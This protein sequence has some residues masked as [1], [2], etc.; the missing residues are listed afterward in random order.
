[1]EKQII[2][3]INTAFKTANLALEIN[4]N[5]FFDTLDANVKTSENTLPAIEK[6]LSSNGLTPNDLTHLAVVIGTG[7]FTGIRVGVALAKGFAVANKNLKL[8]PINS[9]HLMA[10]QFVRDFKPECEFYTIQN[11][12][13]GRFFISKYSRD[14]K[15]LSQPEMVSELPEN[16]LFVGLEEE[17]LEFCD[18]FLNLNS[19]SL[20]DYAK[21]LMVEEN[22]VKV[23]GLTPVYLRLSQAEENLLKSEE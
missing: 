3:A 8:L 15:C 16:G 5:A 19:E 10:F 4:G 6:L 11:A 20:L 7:S 14:G 12:L 2:L 22:F 18:N 21:S 23:N 13:S 9:L 17:K 1:M